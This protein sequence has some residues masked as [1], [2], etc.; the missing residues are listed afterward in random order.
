MNVQLIA[1]A[2]SQ[3]MMPVIWRTAWSKVGIRPAGSSLPAF[4]SSVISSSNPDLPMGLQDVGA[5]F[6]ASHNSALQHWQSTAQDNRR[7]GICHW[8]Q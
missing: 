8:S 5:I 3:A 4:L 2:H 6:D 7:H 1:T